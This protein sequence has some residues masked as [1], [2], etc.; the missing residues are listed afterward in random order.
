V[1]IGDAELTRLSMSGTQRHQ[2]QFMRSSFV[3]S[4][5]LFVHDVLAAVVM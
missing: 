3:P 4:I 2:R 1:S 5:K